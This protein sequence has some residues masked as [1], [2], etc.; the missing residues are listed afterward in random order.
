L[1]VF[2]FSFFFFIY[3]YLFCLLFT[4]IIINLKVKNIFFD[5]R[6]FSLAY[7][8][9]I[10]TYIIVKL[11]CYLSFNLLQ[12]WNFILIRF[13]ISILNLNIII[14]QA[15]YVDFRFARA[16]IILLVVSYFSII[17]LL[18]NIFLKFHIFVRFKFVLLNIISIFKVFFFLNQLNDVIVNNFIFLLEILINVFDFCLRWVAAGNLRD[19]YF[20]FPFIC[21]WLISI[22]NLVISDL[23]LI[24][25]CHLMIVI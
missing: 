23:K 10:N 9:I 18:E 24:W 12:S 15:R 19:N 21:L 4:K 3:I 22:E 17:I 20:F 7:L 1:L 5:F 16:W 6:R 8:S 13:L 14:F 25:N 2:K 11:I